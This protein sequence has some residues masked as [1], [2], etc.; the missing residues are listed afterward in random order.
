M[1]SN[2]GD[3]FDT[4]LGALIGLNE[5]M[6]VTDV[7][8][9]SVIILIILV[10]VIMPFSFYRIKP[11][12]KEISENAAE[13]DLVLIEEIRKMNHLLRQVVD[14]PDKSIKQQDDDEN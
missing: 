5:S 13:R 7:V 2:S 8:V 10:P 6:T 14:N 9:I 12:I 3:F 11:M 1:N 4:I